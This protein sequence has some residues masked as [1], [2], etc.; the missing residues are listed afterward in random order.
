M[1]PPPPAVAEEA[2][3]R[4]AAFSACQRRP[5]QGLASGQSAGSIVTHL[6]GSRHSRGWAGEQ[7]G[8]R[9]LSGRSHPIGL[10]KA[11]CRIPRER[12][13]FAS[14]PEGRVPGGASCSG[15]ESAI[16]H[17]ITDSPAT[18]PSQ[19]GFSW[20]HRGSVTPGICYELCWLASG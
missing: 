12:Q 20:S 5:R 14:G 11:L 4:P 15:L 17:G 7:E 13:P 8:P 18:P 16:P 6:E 1:A 19:P 2:S 3:G 9:V 10:V